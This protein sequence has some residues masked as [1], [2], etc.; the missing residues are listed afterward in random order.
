MF[1]T[2]PSKENGWLMLKT[3]ELL[4]GFQAEDFIGFGGKAIRCVTSF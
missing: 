3:P 2:G 1:L 4:N